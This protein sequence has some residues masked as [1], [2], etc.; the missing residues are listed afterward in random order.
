M[1]PKKAAAGYTAVCTRAFTQA[2]SFDELILRMDI[3]LV[4]TLSLL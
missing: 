1:E 4:G 3:P 2:F